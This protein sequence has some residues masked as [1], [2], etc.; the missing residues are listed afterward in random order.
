MGSSQSGRKESPLRGGLGPW[1]LASIEKRHNADLKFYAEYIK[2]SSVQAASDFTFRRPIPKRRLVAGGK[3]LQ[4]FHAIASTIVKDL[5]QRSKRVVRMSATRPKRSKK[6]QKRRVAISKPIVLDAD[7][8]SLNRITPA[9]VNPKLSLENLGRID[10]ALHSNPYVPET[11]SL[12]PQRRLH[13]VNCGRSTRRRG[14]VFSDDFAV[15][16]GASTAQPGIEES[17][18]PQDILYTEP[19]QQPASRYASTSPR[20]S[21]A[22][23]PG[24]IPKTTAPLATPEPQAGTRR[25]N[26]RAK[27]D[28]PTVGLE[29][30]SPPTQGPEVPTRPDTSSYTRAL[31]Q[32]AVQRPRHRTSGSS[33]RSKQSGSKSRRSKEPQTAVCGESG[34]ASI[35]TAVSGLVALLPPSHRI[36]SVKGQVAE[37][38]RASGSTYYPGHNPLLPDALATLERGIRMLLDERVEVLRTE[39]LAEHNERMLRYSQKR[40]RLLECENEELRLQL[41]AAM[42]RSASTDASLLSRRAKFGKAF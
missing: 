12:Q 1:I 19:C 31:Q 32:Q 39:K 2:R 37:H 25:E 36:A 30:I 42:R 17:D 7:G 6:L 5:Y 38:D 14:A 29:A 16:D 13:V 8:L 21:V 23:L 34:A 26:V 28:S 3:K 9:P 35:D 20:P 11:S 41:S 15:S 24:C 33:R 40:Y 22:E 27:K 18:L 4:Q 10:E